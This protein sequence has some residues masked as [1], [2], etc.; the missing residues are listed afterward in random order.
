M[1]EPWRL[2]VRA[3]NDPTL[4]LE[5]GGYPGLTF[6]TEDEA[7]AAAYQLLS[8]APPMPPDWRLCAVYW[9]RGDGDRATEFHIVCADEIEQP[10]P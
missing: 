5:D 8:G 3:T 2:Y 10:T 4:L 7:H 1:A 9:C 6:N